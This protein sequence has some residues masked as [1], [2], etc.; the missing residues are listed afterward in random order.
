MQCDCLIRSI[1]QNIPQ[2]TLIHILYCASN[3]FFQ[4]GYDKLINKNLHDIV[5]HKEFNFEEQTKSIL[6]KAEHPYHIC[7]T[8]DDVSI[9]PITDDELQP[10]LNGFTDDVA[11]ISLHQN[12]NIVYC[13]SAKA[14]ISIPPSLIVQSEYIIWNW[15]ESDPKYDWGYPHNIWNIYKTSEFKDLINPLNFYH[16]NSLEGAMNTMRNSKKPFM[17]A[18]SKSKLFNVNNNYVKSTVSQASNITYSVEN[19]NKLFLEGFVIDI[20]KLQGIQLNYIHGPH[21]YEF[22]KE[23]QL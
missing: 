15:L 14:P 19:L 12:K 10:L 3:D 18:F 7:L 4:Q 6:L 11:S 1:R 8:D 5:W 2:I 22:I 20:D 17:R 16:P 13:G 9:N 21:D 23:E